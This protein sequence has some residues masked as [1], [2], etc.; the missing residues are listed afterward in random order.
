MLLGVSGQAGPRPFVVVDGKGD[1]FGAP[2][3]SYTDIRF[4]QVI[5][6]NSSHIKVVMRVDEHIPLDPP[7]FMGFVWSFDMDKNGWWSTGP[8]INARV[9]YDIY[10]GWQAYLDRFDGTPGNIYTSF[11][12]SKKRVT[13]V[14]PLADLG[15]P[16]S[17]YWMATTVSANQ[18]LGED[19]APKYGPGF[20]LWFSN[21]QGVRAL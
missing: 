8:D 12:I 16:S 13:F 4:A 10:F 9:A 1:W 14:F 15:N 19:Q 18:V 21:P 11:T 2:G 7:T 20:A 17:F 6:K 3:E 5:Q